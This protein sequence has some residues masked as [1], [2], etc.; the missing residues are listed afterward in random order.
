M[1]AKLTTALVIAKFKYLT[2]DPLGGVQS[3]VKCWHCYA[4][5]QALGTHGL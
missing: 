2:F 5:V 1:H 4:Y 3:E